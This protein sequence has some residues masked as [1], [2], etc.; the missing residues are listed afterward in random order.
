MRALCAS[1]RV[2]SFDADPQSGA[3]AVLRA[4][5]ASLCASGTASLEAVLAHAVPV[6]TYRVDMI[7]E[8]VGRAFLRTD[9]VAL[10]NILLARRAFAELLQP[11]VPPPTIP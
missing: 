9:N 1:H 7:T 11:A 8:L 4:F 5:N 6:V 2:A 3:M 10:P